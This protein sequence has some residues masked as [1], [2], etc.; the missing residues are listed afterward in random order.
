MGRL[1]SEITKLAGIDFFRLAKKEPHPRA[2]IRLLAL[3]HLGSGKTKTEVT[4]MFQV[5]FPTLRLWLTRFIA[6]GIDGLQEKEG[7]GR[8]R[9]LLPEQEEEFRRQVEQLQENREG[10]RVRGQDVQILLKE[11]F[12]VDHA[13]PSVYHVLERC[14][15]S[16]ISSRS[17]H[18]KSD[19]SAQEEFKKNSKKK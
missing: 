19:P 8:K 1:N 7:K 3:G 5:S 10:G 17:K 2:R 16:W 18:P 15:L 11:K 6:E 13:L 12:H 4:E 14:G 9:K